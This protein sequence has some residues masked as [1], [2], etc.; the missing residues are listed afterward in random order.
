MQGEARSR[1]AIQLGWK[2]TVASAMLGLLA[3][4]GGGGSAE[5]P[6]PQTTRTD[7]A[8]GDYH[9]YDMTQTTSLPTGSPVRNYRLTVGYYEVS[10]AGSRRVQTASDSPVVYQTYNANAAFS[11][12]DVSVGGPASCTYTPALQSS[13]PYPRFVGQTWN[14]AST[15][16]CGT[17]AVHS[18][19]IT[20]RETL[21]L[22]IG[23]VEAYRAQRQSISTTNSYVFRQTLVCWYSVAQGILLRCDSVN[24]AGLA[25]STAPTSESTSTQV[26]SAAGGPTRVAVGNTLTRFQGA[27]HVN[28]QGDR[29]GAC[30]A[31]TVNALGVISG[32]CTTIDVGTFAVT[33]S[34]SD[35]G[36]VSIALPGGGA[37]QGNLNTPYSGSGTWSDSGL[38]GTWT[39]SHN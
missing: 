8:S 31:L 21:A 22:P 12:Q 28:Y 33:G 10:A 18:G 15:S 20:G 19:E 26:L 17:T 38:S 29:S 3:A 25:G 2:S 24:T 4:C 37:L 23:N 13:P 35:G 34:V 1:R 7:L 16:T 32:N 39:A 9:V 27:W 11:S 36:V 30:A 5:T 6:Q 14:V